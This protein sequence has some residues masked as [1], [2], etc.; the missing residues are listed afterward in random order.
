M[1]TTHPLT[2]LAL[3]RRLERTEAATSAAFV[4]SHAA[5][6]PMVGAAWIDVAGVYALFDGVS[7]PL[8]QTFGLGMFEAVDDAD[9]E[10]IEAFFRERGAPVFHEVAPFIP[11]ETLAQL[12][13]RG[14][15]P[16]E[17][18]TVLVRAIAPPAD[19][20]PGSSAIVVRRIRTDEADVWARTAGKGWSSESEELAAFVERFG[21]VMVRADGLHCFLAE[22]EGRPVG[23]GALSL[24]ADVALLAGASTIPDARRRGVQRALL[25]ARLRFA[26]GCGI[27]LAMM[28]AQPGSGSQRNAERQGF[29]V[30]Y[31]R[32]KWMLERTAR[33]EGRPSRTAGGC[34]R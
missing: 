21:Q 23:A 7:S 16:I 5:L 17:F 3:A 15:R 30:A 31:T 6:D 29:R 26:A 13:A 11:P 33:V 14:Y 2:D 12:H 24:G 8:T 1:N 32:L 19:G 27:P 4:V 9:F 20:D 22:L 28:V 34:G 18:S 10:R 25:E